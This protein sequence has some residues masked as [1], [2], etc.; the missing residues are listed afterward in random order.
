MAECRL[1]IIVLTHAIWYHE[2]LIISLS[3]VLIILQLF[4][5]MHLDCILQGHKQVVLDGIISFFVEKDEKSKQEN[6]ADEK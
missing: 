1:I 4:K 6:A 5:K 3:A 2:R